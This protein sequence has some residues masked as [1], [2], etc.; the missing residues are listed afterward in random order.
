MA[1]DPTPPPPSPALV[2][3]AKRIRV[4]LTDV[5]GVWTDGR[6]YYFPGP[7]GDL[8]ETKGSTAIDGMALRWWHGAGHISGVIS[9]RDAPGITHRCQMLGVKY[10]FQGHLDKIEPW[11]KICAE[12]GVE[13]DEVCYMGDDLPDTPLL[14]RAGLGV[15]VQNARQEVKS[16]ADYVTIT[17]GGQGALREV[18]ELIMQARGE[19][20]SI[21]QK[22][23]LNG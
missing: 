12:A 2:T 5:D 9:G 18:I 15:A 23:G 7:S 10:I 13:D 4:L 22:Y 17:P 6:L 21:L 1:A 8:V 16:V 11:E 19:W 3:K 20:T 14:R